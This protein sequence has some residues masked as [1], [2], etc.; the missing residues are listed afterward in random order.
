MCLAGSLPMSVQSDDV[1][2]AK[3]GNQS[4]EAK[5]ALLE[6]VLV[7]ATREPLDTERFIGNSAILTANALKLVAHTHV[8]ESLAR[9]AGVNI[10]RGDGQE[11]LPSVRSPVLTGA[12]ACGSVL[13]AVDGI[14]L[15]A[16][17]FC[18]INEM[19]EA[20][21]EQAERIEVLR[22]PMSA[23]YGS[24]A[25]NGL[26]NVITPSLSSES[27]SVLG[28]EAGPED[29]S[30][31]KLSHFG[32]LDEQQ[33]RVDF[34]AAHSDSFR[35]DAGYDQQKLLLKHGYEE[36]AVKV[37][38]TLALSNL[39]QETA[40]YVSGFEVYKDA[41]LRQSNP[42]PE[43][44]RDAQSLR[45]ATQIDYTLDERSHVQVKPYLR[46]TDMAFLQHFLPGDPLEE[47]GHKSF[48]VQS[49]YYL[50]SDNGVSWV[51]GLDVELSDGELTQSQDAPT[52]GSLFLQTTIPAGLHYDYQ[53]D[54]LMV[55]PFAQA[56]VNL[57][58]AL[59]MTAG[60]RYESMDYDYNN[61]MLAGR[62]DDQGN[63]C[64]F[65]GCRYS[66]PDDRSDRF[67][68]WSPKLA[69]LYQVNDSQQVYVNASRGFRAPQA[70]E[71]YR[72][73]RDQSVADLDSVA[74]NSVELGLR[75]RGERMAYELVAFWMN[76]KNVIFRDSDFFNV[77]NGETRHKGLEL[78]ASYQL[79][80]Q[81]DLALAATYADH[82]YE[83]DRLIGGVAI[84]GNQIDSAPKHFS[85]LR[86][87][88]T[89]LNGA[90]AELEWLSQADYYTDPENA[91]QYSGHNLL[92]LRGQW[93][94]SESLTL[95]AQVKNLT[96]RLYAERA[97]FSGF[98]GDRY[99]PG[100]RRTLNVGVELRL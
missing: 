63:T 98:G 91:H 53:V 44:Y 33:F 55:A 97:D 32:S 76:K 23:L 37:V 41:E 2:S 59:S 84:D 24:N 28:L 86:M 95:R 78:A 87:G 60:L 56:S 13:T 49:A 25:M 30:R 15:R 43:A 54:A 77:A 100:A 18:N 79:S 11:Y 70:T 12:G 48:G 6:T 71:L 68:N 69:L 45:L 94:L 38:S 73:Q 34:T 40:G 58:E 31:L 50:E 62:T 1:L 3:P 17:G 99:F 74:M 72:L 42:N 47:N 51:A 85:N 67:G 26:I 21:T 7:T 81:L 20:P 75:G 83:D 39:N 29:Y 57:S 64:G 36:G 16:A 89:F 88:W 66:R 90:R 22:G 61:R 5:P 35:D 19:F 80:K 96:D 52:Q 10:A 92:N 46:Y 9:V 8:Q 82:Q 93:A 65:G 27:G 4:A 14:P